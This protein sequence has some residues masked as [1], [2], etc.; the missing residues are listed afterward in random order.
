[1]G[2]TRGANVVMPNVT[3]PSRRVLYEIYPGK[4]CVTETAEACSGCLAWRIARIGRRVG[5]GP[6]GRRR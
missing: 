3:P 6:G 5:T 2:L 4:A 1:M